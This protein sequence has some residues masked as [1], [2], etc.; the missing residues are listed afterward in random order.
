MLGHPARL[1]HHLLRV[2]R[3]RCG[4]DRRAGSEESAARHADRHSGQP[5]HLHPA[6]HPDVRRAHGPRAVS[7]AQ[8]RGAGRRRAA[9]ASRSQLA[10]A[11]GHRRRSRGPHVGDSRDDPRAGAH[12]PHDGAARAAP[13]PRSARVHPKYRTPAFA[14]V[15]TGVFAAIAAARCPSTCW[16]KWCRSARSS[17]SSSCASACWSCATRGRICRARSA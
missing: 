2:H 9:G 17:R 5:H 14:T 11:V 4:V 12:L 15:V 3:L 6:L 8:R 1:G 13:A 7:A 10:H 16:A